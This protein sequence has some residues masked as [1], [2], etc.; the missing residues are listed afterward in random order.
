M[1]TTWYTISVGKKKVL[2]QTNVRK[3]RDYCVSKNC[4]YL[5]T[6]QLRWS[7]AAAILISKVNKCNYADCRMYNSIKNMQWLVALFNITSIVKLAHF[8]NYLIN[9]FCLKKKSWLTY[10]FTRDFVRSRDEYVVLALWLMTTVLLDWYATAML[11]VYNENTDSSKLWC[12]IDKWETYTIT[13]F[14]WF[15]VWKM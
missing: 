15:Y 3:K 13:L 14:G 10:A 9:S 7:T 2:Y 11:Y 4:F 5:T 1:V 12:P 6:R 8:G